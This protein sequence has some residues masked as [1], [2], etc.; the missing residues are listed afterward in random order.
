MSSQ[1]PAISEPYAD[2]QSLLRTVR[3][4]KEL[5]E[6]LTGQRRSPGADL[7]ARISAVEQAVDFV[8]GANSDRLAAEVQSARGGQVDLATRITQ[9]AASVP[10]AF[11]ARV[12]TAGTGLTGGGNLSADRTFALDLTYTDARYVQPA[13]AVAAGTGLTGGGNL[14]ADRTLSLDLTY[15]AVGTYVW[16]TS[17]A[18]VAGAA[19]LGS[20]L[21]PAQSGN[22]RQMSN[23]V[24]GGGLFV[25]LS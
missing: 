4:L 17:G 15:G 6:T 11:I 2:M 8:L 24:T 16:S 10:A 1:Y 25:R 14:S 23:S 12:V 20:A 9:V 21:T 7:I 3:E 18:T 22:W 19:A 13:R 5:V